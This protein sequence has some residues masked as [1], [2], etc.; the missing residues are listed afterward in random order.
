[1]RDAIITSTCYVKP[2]AG[3]SHE[4]FDEGGVA[5]S[6][7]S[8]Y[9]SLLCKSCIKQFGRSIVEATLMLAV[10]LGFAFTGKAQ[11]P[12][13]SNPLAK[14]GMA[15]SRILLSPVNII[16]HAYAQVEHYGSVGVVLSPI[17][18]PVAVPGGTMATCSD[19]LTGLG[20]MLMFEQF[21]SVKYPWQSFNYEDSEHWM[22]IALKVMEVTS[23]VADKTQEVANQVNSAKHGGSAGGAASTPAASPASAKPESGY[24]SI[25]GPGTLG[26]G[27]TGT[28]KLRVGGKVVNA[29]WSQGGTSISVYGS[30]DHARAMAGN[31]P[32]KSG[33]FRTAIRA[34][35]NGKTYYKTIYI[36]K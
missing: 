34:T 11:T 21:Q 23:E 24:G 32:I 19:I 28:Y 22:E 26:R 17:L 27:A 9:R 4:R 15:L 12:V 3:Y 33:R 30:G 5:S 29:D 2:Y 35:Y 18:I 8:R 13:A 1:M 31:P 7:T 20:E 16:G 14:E 10:A 6:I 36:Q 25:S